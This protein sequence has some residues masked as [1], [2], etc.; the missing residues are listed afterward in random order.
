MNLKDYFE[1]KQGTGI[2]ATTDPEGRVDLAIYAKPLVIDE[3]TLAF[4]MRQRLSHQNLKRTMH[5][6]YMFLES[7]GG[8]E[9][10]RLYLTKVREE[11]NATLA[12]AMR[13]QQPAIFPEG[14]D[15]NKF[16]VIFHVDR[17]RPLVG[18]SPSE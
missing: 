13:K 2:L 7:G 3:T 10:K 11:I 17:V 1:S 14:D 6:A 9:G 15:S 12:E 4:V 18:D 5:V 16:V 8:Y